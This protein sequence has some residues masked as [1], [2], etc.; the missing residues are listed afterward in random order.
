MMAGGMTMAAQK[1]TKSVAE[2]GKTVSY[3]AI[4]V[5]LYPSE[6]QAELI[7]K[8]FGCCRYLWNQ[9]LA[10]TQEFY[11]A[12]DI[13]YIPAPAKYKKDAPFLR[14]VDS[15]ALCS[16]YQNLRQAFLDFFRA[17]KVFGY[18][19]F[20]TKKAQKDTFTVPCRPY[21]TGPSI[22]LTKNGIHLVKLGVIPAKLHRKPEPDWELR[23]V[24]VT[25]TR[26]GKYYCS[27][28]FKRITEI[29][30][31]VIPTEKTTIGI[32]HALNHFYV[33]SE[34]REVD[35]PTYLA[36]AKETLAY[37]Q[38][39]LSRMQRG[40]RNYEEQ[41]QKIRLLHEH[42]ANQRRDFI[43]KESRRITNAW[44]AVCIRETDLVRMAQRVK[45]VNV[46]DSAF[47]YFRD[48]LKYKLRQQGKQLL[49]VSPYALTA[50]TCHECGFVHEGLSRR[51]TDWVCPN[52]GAK[53]L[54]GVNAA[55]NIRDWGIQE[56][57][58]NYSETD[59]LSAVS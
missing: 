39:K 36:K 51:E 54:R 7:E 12:A 9:M 26:S 31:P 55:R 49:V 28:V 27:I 2:V 53:L 45:G 15:R 25:K 8:T 37:Q 24:T 21:R 16:V 59:A 40:S 23:Y 58:E 56:F 1:C 44:E 52:C 43:Q 38:R 4:R 6:E 48:C 5:R 13:H 17:P 3:P 18:P 47:G 32:N 34:G 10:D 33:D 30:K 22:Y 11:A 20:K 41:A 46:L 50:K 57:R 14:E 35:L 42:I 19:Q 29:P